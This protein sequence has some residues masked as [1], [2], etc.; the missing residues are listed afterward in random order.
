MRSVIPTDARL[1][2]TANSFA[3]RGVRGPGRAAVHP[4]LDL[5][6]FR[7]ERLQGLCDAISCEITE[8]L[9]L[10]RIY[11]N[12]Y[13]RVGCRMG[14]HPIDIHPPPGLGLHLTHPSEHP[15]GM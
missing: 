13:A 14:V 9:G 11:A 12:L 2:E 15:I 6:G 7:H 1:P 4:R 8:K 5:V 3:E 10:G